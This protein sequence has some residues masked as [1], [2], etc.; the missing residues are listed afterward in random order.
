VRLDDGNGLL[1]D[2]RS[3]R[4]EG[5]V[6]RTVILARIARGQQLRCGVGVLFDQV[7]LDRDRAVPSDAQRLHDGRTASVRTRASNASASASAGAARSRANVSRASASAVGRGL[8][9]AGRDQT[10]AQAQQSER[11]LGDYAEVLPPG[12]GM[13]VAARCGGEVPANLG[14]CGT[15]VDGDML[16]VWRGVGVDIGE[17]FDV[18]A[19]PDRDRGSLE[20]KQ[21]RRIWPAGETGGLELVQELD[22]RGMLIASYFN[23]AGDTIVRTRPVFP[24]PKVAR[25][26]GSGSIDDTSNFVAA[27][28]PVAHDG[29]VRWLFDRGGG[30][31]N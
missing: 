30:T 23:D 11:A 27:D 12:R 14:N 7:R 10:A 29:D 4:H 8:W 13:F 16:A 26:D 2:I 3:L 5:S 1:E 21:I 17:A 19:P 15:S 22:R 9:F 18:L 31:K 25:Y 20:P 6:A 28:P 24:Y